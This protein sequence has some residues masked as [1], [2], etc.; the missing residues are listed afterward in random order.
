MEFRIDF[1][2]LALQDLDDICSWAV[3]EAPSRGA[4]WFFRLEE[5]ILSLRTM[6]ER[7]PVALEFARST[8]SIRRMVYGSRP[9]GYKIY[10]RIVGESVQVLHVRHGKREAP[11]LSDLFPTQ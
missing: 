4:D 8:P 2:L 5:A 6:P 10:Y 11:D 7:Y 3:S 9:H 1:T